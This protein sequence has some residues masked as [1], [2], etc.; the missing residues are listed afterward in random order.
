MVHMVGQ[1]LKHSLDVFTGSESSPFMKKLYPVTT[2]Y[3]ALKL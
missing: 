2:L 3:M 1:T